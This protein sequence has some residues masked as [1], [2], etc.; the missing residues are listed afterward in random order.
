[1]EDEVSVDLHA[2]VAG[3]DEIAVTW[4]DAVETV[5]EFPQ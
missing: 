4:R 5:H 1:V 2:G 3:L